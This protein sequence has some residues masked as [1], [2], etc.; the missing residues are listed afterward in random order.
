MRR[1]IMRGVIM[2][3]V[4]VLTLLVPACGPGATHLTVEGPPIS[5]EVSAAIQIAAS[6]M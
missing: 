1:T 5:P 3:G 6:V 2:L 4:M